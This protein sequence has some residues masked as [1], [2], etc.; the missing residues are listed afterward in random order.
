MTSRSVAI[1]EFLENEGRPLRS[2]LPE[3]RVQALPAL[4]HR[5][6]LLQV[7]VFLRANAAEE[8]HDGQ[9]H[10]RLL[11]LLEKTLQKA[12]PRQP[13]VTLDA[14]ALSMLDAATALLLDGVAVE[15]ATWIRR[16]EEGEDEE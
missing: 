12:V 1:V 4:L 5:N 16:L 3:S 15:V 7:A 8:S 6:G 14:G 9:Q 2:D 11:D 13:E 10:Q